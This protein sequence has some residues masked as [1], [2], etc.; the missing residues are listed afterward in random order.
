MISLP[1]RRTARIDPIAALRHDQE[2]PTLSLAVRFVEKP[3]F[4]YFGMALYVP[5]NG[6]LQQSGIVG[7]MTDLTRVF[8]G[9]SS[10][11][12]FDE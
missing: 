10:Q 1:A 4:T 12:I 11:G 9:A 7:V 8:Y 5:R 6:A 2:D 3:P